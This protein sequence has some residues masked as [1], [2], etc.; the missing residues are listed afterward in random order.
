MHARIVSLAPNATSILVGLGARKNLAG[1]SRWCADVAYVGRL[2]RLGDCWAMDVEPLAKLRPDFVIG[3]VPFRPE[4]VEEILKLPSTFIALNPRTLE[5]IFRDIEFLGRIADRVKPAAGLT[6]SMKAAFSEIRARSSRF[7]ARPRVYCEAWPK[8]RI[9]SPPWVAELVE[10][11]GGRMAVS[12]GTTVTDDSVA[13]SA[14]EVI[15]LAWTAT[16]DRA[17][18]ESALDNPHWRD[19]PAV[20]NGR[21]VVIRD[22]WLNTP[23]P[24]LING[25]RAL[26]AA[27]HPSP[28][29]IRTRKQLRKKKFHTRSI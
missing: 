18:P 11:A 24:P 1:V 12:A 23:G 28:K 27:L 15:V 5:D 2:P 26:F 3:S 6:R 13:R 9:S 22:E 8:P 21:V 20:R 17:K 25:V 29:S 7:S 4:V 16:G 10:I 14:P 19:V